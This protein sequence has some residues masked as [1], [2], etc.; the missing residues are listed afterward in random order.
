M[1]ASIG[2]LVDINQSIRHHS[3]ESH[4]LQVHVALLLYDTELFSTNIYPCLYLN[5][6]VIIYDINNIT[7]N[8]K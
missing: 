5:M 1:Q 6:N 3:S 4:H 2:E 8:S 7:V